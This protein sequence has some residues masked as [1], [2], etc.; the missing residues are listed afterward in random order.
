MT[1]KLGED[2][3]PQCR[4]IELYLFTVSPE[5]EY[6]FQNIMFFELFLKENSEEDIDEH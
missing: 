1:T 4:N 3:I 2:Y 5:L 6:S